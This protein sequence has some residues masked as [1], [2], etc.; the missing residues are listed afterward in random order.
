MSALAHAPASLR[1]STRE[2]TQMSGLEQRALIGCF[3]ADTTSGFD[4]VASLQHSGTETNLHV[5][6]SRLIQLFIGSDRFYREDVTKHQLKEQRN[7]HV[8]VTC[9]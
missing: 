1:S 4:R 9:M 6:K 3:L 2:H 5:A 8:H 7:I